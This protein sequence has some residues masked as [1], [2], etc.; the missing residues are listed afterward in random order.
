LIA[1]PLQDPGWQV[2]PRRKLRQAPAPSHVPSRPQVDGSEAGQ[3]PAL[4]GAPP[5]G[6]NAQIPGAPAV[7]H[8]LHVSV[9]ALLQQTPSTQNPLA[10]SPS[11]PQ[12][13]PL[14]PL[15]LLVPLQATADASPPLSWT[16]PSARGALEWLP[17]P[18]AQRPR[19]THPTA[20]MLK[21]RAARK[22]IIS[23][24]VSPGALRARRELGC[25]RSLRAS[26]DAGR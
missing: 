9:H 17:H 1:A 22:L 23:R 15:I 5:A 6:T 24:N 16:N 7:L 10:Q 3:T 2:V 18:A 21:S 12:A 4:G 26:C 8:D 19:P 14:V 11:H 25:V 13:A 20:T